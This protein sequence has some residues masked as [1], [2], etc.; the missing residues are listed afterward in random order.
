[1]KCDSAS[2]RRYARGRF[3]ARLLDYP[4]SRE[5]HICSLPDIKNYDLFR[6]CNDPQLP[7]RFFT[8]LCLL[9]RSHCLVGGKDGN[10]D[11]CASSVSLA[12]RAQESSISNDL[13]ALCS[14]GHPAWSFPAGAP[15]LD[16]EQRCFRSR[17]RVRPWNRPPSLEHEAY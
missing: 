15:R 6:N 2:T 10:L 8:L 14:S 7:G 13:P 17:H 11:W 1:M 12:Q 16:G 4:S 3:V 9:S 5:R